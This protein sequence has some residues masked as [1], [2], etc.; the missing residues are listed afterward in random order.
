MHPILLSP[1]HGSTGAERRLFARLPPD[2]R[3]RSAI[4]SGGAQTH[5]TAAADHKAGCQGFR[6]ALRSAMASRTVI[7]LMP[8][9]FCLVLV[10]GRIVFASR[11]A[12][13]PTPNSREDRR[14]R[15]KWTPQKWSPGTEVLR[16]SSTLGNP[17]SSK[18]G[19]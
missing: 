4:G 11:A 3:S 10:A 16:L 7:C 13:A 2:G 17:R 14:V 8:Y 6:W 18:T 12:S 19:K 1:L 9:A 15:R 5:Q